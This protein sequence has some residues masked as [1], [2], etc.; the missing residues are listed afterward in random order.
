MLCGSGAFHVA[1]AQIKVASR[2]LHIW[3]TSG[4]NVVKEILETLMSK[5]LQDTSAISR[6]IS[7]MTNHMEDMIK[8]MW[9]KCAKIISENN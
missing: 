5:G 9:V 8:S 7:V 4:D 3:E 2:I 6:S 1:I